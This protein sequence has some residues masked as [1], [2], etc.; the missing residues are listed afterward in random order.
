[1]SVRSFSNPNL[2]VVCVQGLGFVGSAMAVSI[3]SACNADG[4]PIFN[5]FGVDLP[6]ESGLAA[7]TALNEGRFPRSTTDVKL[8]S[9]T[10]SAQVNRNLVATA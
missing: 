6:S 9:A 7:I 4:Q 5:V 2:P 8:K 1:M 3:A 10:K